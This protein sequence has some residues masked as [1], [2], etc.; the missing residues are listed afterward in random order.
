MSS[1]LAPAPTASRARRRAWRLSA[2]LASAGLSIAAAVACQS[3]ESTP[4]PEPEPLRPRS[5][6]I[7]YVGLSFTRPSLSAD[8]VIGFLEPLFGRAARD[9][10]GHAGLEVQR[11]VFLTVTPD[12]RTPDQVVVR[13]ELQLARG[14]ER[15]TVLSVP[16][17]GTYGDVYIDTVRVALA[18]AAAVEAREAGAMEPF[19]LQYRTQSPN[20][21]DLLVEV[22]FEG[23]RTALTVRANAARTSLLPGHVNQAAFAG[24]PYETLAGTVWFSL[25]R[26][27]FGFFSTRAYGVTSGAAQNFR[28]FQL[29]PHDWLRLT[30]TP[31]LS[32]GLV[33]VGFEVLTADG[34]R[35]P[36]AKAPASY[37]AGEQ[38]Q[39]SVFRM[40]DN[41]LAQE[42]EAP[43]SSTPFEVPYY[44]DDPLGGGV[45][46]V[47]ATGVRG[48]FKIA[49]AVESPVRFL[50]DVEFVPYQGRV[51]IPAELPPVMATCE[52][53]GSTTAL[54]GRFTLRFD[55][56]STVRESPSLTHP[57]RGPVWLSVYR[58]ADVT[59]SGPRPGSEPVATFSAPDVDI[60]GGLSAESYPVDAELPA[61]DYQI[62]GFMDIDGNS[63]AD[64]DPDE[65]DPVTLPIGGYKVQCADNP[66]VVEF[67]LLLPAGR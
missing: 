34:R 55:A 57:L 33:D 48:S 41:M 4:V 2:A 67:A 54:R 40:V 11:G 45:V 39:Q 14:A 25:S 1:S 66:V 19:F 5:E 26:D 51:D 46:Q 59:I 13:M 53:R 22:R 15:R 56:S 64:G 27:E 62:L 6:P 49:Y 16:A 31:R 23:G 37:V 44:Y 47:I 18:R 36:F 17:S 9:G 30:V 24:R 52:D 42:A 21:G 63:P 10:R 60:R 38:F 61:G 3:G 28:D 58:A 43:G 32:D 35:V 50:Q 8:E 29:L 12:G 20:G 7:E 65:G